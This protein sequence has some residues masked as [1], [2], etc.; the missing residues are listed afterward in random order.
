MANT[1][2]AFFRTRIEGEAA[3]NKLLA[4]GFTGNEV[5]FVAGGTRG[6]EPPVKESGEEG[7]SEPEPAPAAYLTD[8]IGVAVEIMALIVPGTGPLVAAGPLATAITQMTTGVA[9]EG[10]AGILR[11]HGVS[12]EK[13]AYYAEGIR[14]GGSLVMVHDVTEEA[15]NNAR[16]IL[17]Q[18]G[19]I[20]S[21]E[22]AADP[23]KA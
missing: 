22:S 14:M 20:T 17:E 10:I 13:A 23:N 8:A 7:S 4:R 15:Q 3:R 1:V 19:A 18:C 11:D 9:P 5:S 21:H 6:N 12:E 2:A 16:G